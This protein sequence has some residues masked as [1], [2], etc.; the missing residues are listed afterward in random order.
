LV[1]GIRY[2][3]PSLPA[4][5]IVLERGDGTAAEMT[6]EETMAILLQPRHGAFAFQPGPLLAEEMSRWDGRDW[7]QEEKR[8]VQAALAGCQLWRWGYTAERWWEQLPEMV[9]RPWLMVNG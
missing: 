2:A 5:V 6:T 1:S 3:E 4:Q 9:K 7:R 8:I